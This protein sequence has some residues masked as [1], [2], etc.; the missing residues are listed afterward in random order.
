[1]E[2]QSHPFI[3]GIIHVVM[4]QSS[5]LEV[6]KS[7]PAYEKIIIGVV[8][9]AAV[10][11]FLLW[12]LNTS[13]PYAPKE[14]RTELSNEAALEKANANPDDMNAPIDSRL[15]KSLEVPGITH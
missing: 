13:E 12:I 4:E 1:M 6:K 2:I 15:L 5:S 14:E 11:G 9:L 8:F 3:R 7:F 10:I